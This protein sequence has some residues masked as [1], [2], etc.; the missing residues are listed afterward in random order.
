MEMNPESLSE[1]KLVSAKKSGVTRLSLGVQSMNQAPLSAVHRP[2]SA[3]R[4]HD[5]LELVSSLWKGHLNLAW[6]RRGITMEKQ[7]L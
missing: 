3:K 2:C 7:K 6:R 4:T 1:E 5:A